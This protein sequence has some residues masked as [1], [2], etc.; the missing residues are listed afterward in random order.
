MAN[1][2]AADPAITHVAAVHCE[3]TSGILNPI[4]EIASVAANAGCALIIDAI[5]S[6]G[7]LA[8]EAADIPFAA[9]V[10]SANKCLEGVPGMGFAIIEN[11]ALK[12]AEGNA[13][14]LSLDL[15]DQWCYLEETGQWRF[16]PPTHVVAALNQALEEH[17]AEGGV[18]GRGARYGGNCRVLVD[19]LRGMGFETYL[20]DDL[21][22]PIIVAVRRPRDSNFDFLAFYD[23]LTERGVVIYP[24]SVTE[25][26]TFR[27]GCIGRVDEDD[28]KRALGAMADVLDR[29]GVKD[30]SPNP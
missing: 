22:A 26:E 7:A 15:F 24:G 17:A 3:T 11:A 28:M 20:P 27:V 30:R 14:S 19:G 9:L 8:L 25:E 29:M 6:F 4:A 16:T 5:S 1:I 2:L 13:P 21:Q 18:A 10:G 23:S 12:A